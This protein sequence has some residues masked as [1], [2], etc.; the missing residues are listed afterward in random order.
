MEYRDRV[1]I[2][3][4]QALINRGQLTADEIVKMA[5][6]FADEMCKVRNKPTAPETWGPE[7]YV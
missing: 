1:R 4:M 6:V 5:D 2:A 7:D 3:A